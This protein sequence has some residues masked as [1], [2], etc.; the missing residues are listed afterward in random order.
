MKN[1]NIKL[2]KAENLEYMSTL[3]NESIRLIYIDPPFNTSKIQKSR[4][5]KDKKWPETVMD[6]EYYD[7]FGNGIQ[8]YL[9]FMKQRL[10]HCHR[11]LDENGVLCVHLDYR[12]VHYI[13]CLLDE[14]FGEDNIDIGS[15]HLINEIIWCYRTGGAGKTR[16]SRK[17][18]TILCYSKEKDKYVFNLKKEKI[19]YEKPFMDSKT[20]KC[21][22]ENLN[23]KDIKKIDDCLKQKKA[24]P[25]SLKDKL[26]DKHYVTVIPVDWFTKEKPIINMS[27]EGL[28]YPTQKPIVLLNKII[29]TFTNEGDLVAD[30]FLWLWHYLRI[31]P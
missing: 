21:D 4:K 17:H 6:I 19:Y 13:K 20:E 12:S 25:D 5:L 15:D 3:S 11:L 9:E 27:N 22:I 18:D 2:A 23:D 29:E 16:F 10:R 8:G 26:F 14:I 24:F 31:C 30:F 1:Q 7:S 28:G